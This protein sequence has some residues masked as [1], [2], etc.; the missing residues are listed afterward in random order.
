M[1]KISEKVIAS[2]F[3][4]A[5]ETLP[6]DLKSTVP[7][8]EVDELGTVIN[9]PQ[10]SNVV[11]GRDFQPEFSLIFLPFVQRIGKVVGRSTMLTNRFA[12]VFNK[13]TMPLG[14]T[15]QIFDVNP[16]QARQVNALAPSQLLDVN[17]PDTKAVYLKLNREDQYPV[18]INIAK[19]RRIF[20]SM[21]E[22]QN[23]FAGI[24]TS[25]YKGDNYDSY[26]IGKS[27]INTAVNEN[28]IV[29]RPIAADTST[30]VALKVLLT[31]LQA[32]IDLMQI[33]SPNFNAMMSVA[34]RPQAPLVTETLPQDLVIVMDSNM[35]AS[36]TVN[37]LA[38]LFNIS[39]I[40]MRDRIITVDGFDNAGIKYVLMDRAYIHIEEVLRELR[41]FHDVQ[42]N[43]LN[44]FYDRFDIVGINPLA[45][46]VA[47]VTNNAAYLPNIPATAV[48][49]SATT[50]KVG[51]IITVRTVPANSTVSKVS[52]APA[53]ADFVDGVLK[54]KTTGTFTV[55]AGSA[56]SPTVTIS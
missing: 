19:A 23:F 15:V 2:A 24:V 9:F 56:T 37:V 10:I 53:V 17:N 8:M 51:D 6:A 29:I 28:K 5:R 31:Q 35:K 26:R 49:V 41:T 39:L 42:K 12:T 1:K 43:S 22:V 32:D 36:L 27:V 14:D 11:M 52:S 55:T 33:P 54:V 3:N 44:Y 16:A 48:Q 4:S 47:Y 40:E 46:A 34:D 13:G 45:N 20:T 21:A 18:T 38:V 30:D 50:G 7:Q 25:L